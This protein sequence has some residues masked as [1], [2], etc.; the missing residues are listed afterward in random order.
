MRSLLKRD[1]GSRACLHR[2]RCHNGNA[3]R[4]LKRST[5]FSSTDPTV[6]SAHCA[7]Q[8]RQQHTSDITSALLS[9]V[10][11][12]MDACPCMHL[13]EAGHRLSQLCTLK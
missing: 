2:P 5:E 12:G 7:L 10:W 11:S 6:V 1:A 8:N 9:Y 4:A 13:V 3:A